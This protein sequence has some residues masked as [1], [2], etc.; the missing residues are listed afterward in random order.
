MEKDFKVGDSGL[1]RIKD[2]AEQN[3][4]DYN[5]TIRIL[6]EN[7]KIIKRFGKTS[8]LEKTV[9]DSFLTIAINK[10]EE[11]ALATS[12][13][14]KKLAET[15]KAY[16]TLITTYVQNGLNVEFIN[17]ALYLMV[18]DKEFLKTVETAVNLKKD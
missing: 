5:D 4:V 12:Q 14:Q 2:W 13:K 3:Q 7:K 6:K 10:R 1:C 17:K 15:K 16:V 9:L 18:N 8:F 11:K